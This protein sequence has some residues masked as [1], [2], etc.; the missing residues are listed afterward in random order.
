VGDIPTD[1]LPKAQMQ[2][3]GSRPDIVLYRRK[4]V[5]RT[6]EGQWIT[7]PAQIALVEIKYTRDTDPSRTHTDPYKQHERFYQLLRRRHPSAIIERKSII[8]GIAGAVFDQATVRPLE[9]IGIKGSLLRSCVH[10]LQRHAIQSLHGI[11]KAR[12]E[13]IRKKQILSQNK[14]PVEGHLNLGGRVSM[15][16]GGRRDQRDQGGGD[17][18]AEKHGEG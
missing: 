12:Q 16:R 14:A 17:R 3:A 8:L 11:W 7:S 13:K 5:K 15:G 4:S 10:K 2:A 18:R 6:P 9:S 1:L